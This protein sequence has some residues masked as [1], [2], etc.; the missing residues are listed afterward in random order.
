MPVKKHR[1]DSEGDP[2]YQFVQDLRAIDQRVVTPPPVVPDPSTVLLQMPRW[3]K[4]FPVI[5]LTA[6]FFRIPREESSQPLFAFTWKG[7]QRTWT[8]LPQG[9]T[10]SPTLSSQVLRNDLK[11]V[12]LPGGSTLRQY[13]DGLLIA[14]KD[15]DT[16]IMDSAYLCPTLTEKGSPGISV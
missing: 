8:H 10:G 4:C 11:D 15:E 2:E 1:Q 12:E 3:A 9:F 5:D 16:C 13:V 7:Q 6:A 14:S